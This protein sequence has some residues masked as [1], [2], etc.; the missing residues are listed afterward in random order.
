MLAIAIFF[1]VIQFIAAIGLVAVIVTSVVAR[2][3]R[4]IVWTNFL[5]T[6]V[7]FALS[8][9]VLPVIGQQSGPEPAYGI[10][11]TQ[12]V[13]VYGAPTL[14]AFSGFSLIVQL[15]IDMM[16]AL[17]K[18]QSAASFSIRLML[19]IVP[20]IVYIAVMIGALA[21]GLNHNI[22]RTLNDTYCDIKPGTYRSVSGAV[23]AVTLLL[24]VVVL[25]YVARKLYQQ[26]RSFKNASS[27]KSL[28]KKAGARGQLYDCHSSSAYLLALVRD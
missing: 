17:G 10:C 1:F 6:W 18:R 22:Q 11:L 24:S 7:I 21:F 12:A 9:V 14:T 4:N 28:G 2:L 3:E 20:Y 5:I 8:F 13:L 19:I 26:S 27:T 15:Y 23:V 25:G 16:V